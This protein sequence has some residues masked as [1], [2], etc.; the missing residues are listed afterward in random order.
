MYYSSPY[1]FRR[2]KHCLLGIFDIDLPNDVK[3]VKFWS[4]YLGGGSGGGERLARR[5]GAVER[6]SGGR[7]VG[8]NDIE[9]LSQVCD[10]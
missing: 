6:V 1:W 10:M 9:C 8:H 5:S 4:K 2:I 3:R 7:G